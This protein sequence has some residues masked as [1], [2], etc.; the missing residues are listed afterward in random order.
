MVSAQ[1]ALA[2]ESPRAGA[3]AAAAWY[4]V[5]GTLSLATS[6]VPI[7]FDRPS[8]RILYSVFGC[9]L[10]LLGASGFYTIHT[11]DAQKLRR[12]WLFV[13][14]SSLTV[15][16]QFVLAL[17]STIHVIASTD[18]QYW[19][20]SGVYIFACVVIPLVQFL[21]LSFSVY[22]LYVLASFLKS[23]VASSCPEEKLHRIPLRH[24][25][26]ETRDYENSFITS[27]DT[28]SKRG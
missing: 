5:W 18:T 25:A 3:F 1:P 20:T 12:L 15:V 16:V 27:G 22:C 21:I 13:F 9:Y 23:I 19:I 17:S 2:R 4:L 8:I 24:T 26:F 7:D 28:V 10:L 11:C 14:S 6:R